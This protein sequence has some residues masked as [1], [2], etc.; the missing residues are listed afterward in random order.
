MQLSYKIS[1]FIFALFLSTSVL[2]NTNADGLLSKKSIVNSNYL[3]D[4]SKNPRLILYKFSIYGSGGLVGSGS[5]DT[6]SKQPLSLGYKTITNYTKK[7]EREI[8]KS[9]EVMKVTPGILETGFSITAT[10]TTQGDFISSDICF[11][12]SKLNGI[13]NYES[14]D[15]LNVSSYRANVHWFLKSG[16][17]RNLDFYLKDKFG[18]LQKYTFSLSADFIKYN[19]S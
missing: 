16:E 13:S 7:I 9:G 19:R 10:P 15:L 6:G 8:N 14:S 2:A 1:Y 17:V 5:F 4:V 18:N 11:E 3:V 12:Y